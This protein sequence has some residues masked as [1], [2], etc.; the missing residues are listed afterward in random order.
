MRGVIME[1]KNGRAVL[2]TKGGGFVNIKDK[3]YSIGDK[4]NITTNMGPLCAMAASLFIVCAGIGSY[5]VPAGYVSVDIN[6]SL[7]M[8]LNPYNRV[9]D[10]Q[11]FND[12]AR[13]LLS[14]TDI[15]GRGAEE[16][17][18]ML[19]KAS[20]EIG[21]INDNNRDVILEVVP[22]MIRPDMER[23]N[24]PNIEITNETADRETLRMSQNIG[25]S[26]AKVKA[27]EEYTEKNGG[28]IRSNAVKFNDKSAKEMRAIMRGDSYLPDIKPPEIPPPNPM[29]K[30]YAP[31][32]PRPQINGVRDIKP[33]YNINSSTTPVIEQRS[34][35]TIPDN[36][37]PKNDYRPPE[38]ALTQTENKIPPLP[39]VLNEP[40]I[41]N[42]EPINNPIKIDEKPQ[43]DNILPNKAINKPM[44]EV[45]PIHKEK[46][47]Q[48]KTPTQGDSKPEIP[49]SV[50]PVNIDNSFINSHP[51]KEE[52]PQDETLEQNK[53]NRENS[54]N[55]K[56]KRSR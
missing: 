28:D 48:E 7:M 51:V 24:H 39:P 16:S 14:K 2:L 50:E 25:V 38:N 56:S 6:P 30:E 3:G 40:Q 45:Q 4:V 43:D 44:H 23:I 54:D 49:N 27:I 34:E 22:G 12:D 19:I 31:K 33:H 17:V 8:T 41:W 36:Q 35:K 26:M 9:I 11:T 18:E 5:F 46:N 55:R 1:T 53:S 37:P 20:E 29:P 15:K 13:I 42:I 47:P 10:I 52:K 21:Y 32:P